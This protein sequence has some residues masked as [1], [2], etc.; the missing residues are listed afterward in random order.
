MERTDSEINSPTKLSRPGPWRGPTVR[1]I[2]PL[3][4]HDSCQ[5]ILIFLLM[6][7][8]CPKGN[9]YGWKEVDYLQINYPSFN[10]SN[11]SSRVE[12]VLAIAQKE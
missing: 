3:S 11:S 5:L 7:F 8:Y 2:L 6:I 1:L 4:Y 9:G 10:D 12:S